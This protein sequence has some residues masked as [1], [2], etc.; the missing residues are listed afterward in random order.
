VIANSSYTRR[1]AVSVGVARQITVVPCG[2]E[3]F[4]VSGSVAVAPTVL[5]VGRLVRRKGFDRLIEAMAIVLQ[6]LPD[7]V[8]EIV[9]DGPERDALLR[10]ADRLGVA[11]A[12]H[13]LGP[14]EDAELYR[15]YARAWCFALP[16][17]RYGND[18]EGFGLVYLEA[19]IAALPSIGGRDSGA[20]EAIVDSQTGI[21]VDGRDCKEIARAVVTL[22]QDREFAKEMGRLG[23]ARALREFSWLENARRIDDAMTAR[24][25]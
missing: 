3:D 19:A 20:A 18:V 22:L 6:T 4:A 14:V 13:F 5:A 10:L 9:G 7:A 25:A 1:L 8:C 21:I 11:H 24:R 2:V 16:V 17:R 15:A 12:V 23:R